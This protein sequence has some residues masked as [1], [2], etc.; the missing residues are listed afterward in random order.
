MANREEIIE[1]IDQL[2][3]VGLSVIA[4]QLDLLEQQNSRGFS[5]EFTDTISTVHERN[6]DISGEE[7]LEIATKAVRAHRRDR[8]R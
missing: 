4:K 6:K 2:D 1:R 8:R 5:K 3:E 7:A